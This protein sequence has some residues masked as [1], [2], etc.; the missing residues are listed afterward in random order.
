MFSIFRS[1]K[2]TFPSKLEFYTHNNLKFIK[3]VPVQSSGKTVFLETMPNGKNFKGITFITDKHYNIIGHHDYIMKNC[4]DGIFMDIDNKK[5]HMGFGELLRLASIIEMNENGLDKIRMIS[6]PNAMPF[7]IKYKFMPEIDDM[8][9]VFKVLKSIAANKSS[10]GNVPQEAEKILNSIEKNRLAN[11]QLNCLEEVS[12]LVAKYVRGNAKRWNET[13]L[14]ADI[15]MSLIKSDVKKY[16][17]FYNKLF[18][19]H[20]ID[21]TI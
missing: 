5:Q 12:S 2:P 20:G 1:P 3:R 16:A 13:K 8:K 21:Y 11:K 18:K 6:I 7:H 19:K 15:P 4:L 10:V 17:S 14:S 9:T